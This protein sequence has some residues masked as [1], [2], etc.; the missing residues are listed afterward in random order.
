MDFEDLE[1][2]AKIAKNNFKIR[3]NPNVM[4]LVCLAKKFDDDALSE[5]KKLLKDKDSPPVDLVLLNLENGLTIK[6]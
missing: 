1:E 3:G 2:C 5:Y 4:R 6:N